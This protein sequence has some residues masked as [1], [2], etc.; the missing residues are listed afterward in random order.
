MHLFGWI[1][2][3]FGKKYILIAYDKDY[4]YGLDERFFKYNNGN[5]SMFTLIRNTL[6]CFDI[7]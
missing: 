1:F 5:G 2:T 4:F 7:L 6:K 3:D